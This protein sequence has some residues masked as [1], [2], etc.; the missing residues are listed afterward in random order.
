MWILE[1]EITKIPGS[2]RQVCEFTAR[3]KVML[4]GIDLGTLMVR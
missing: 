3:Y 2:V 4:A 1:T